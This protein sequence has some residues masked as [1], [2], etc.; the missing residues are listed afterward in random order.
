MIL[1]LLFSQLMKRAYRSLSYLENMLILNFFLDFLRQRI[2]PAHFLGSKELRL[3]VMLRC[4]S[5]HPSLKVDLPLIDSQPRWFAAFLK[6]FLRLLFKRIEL[7]LEL[8]FLQFGEG[9][10][11]RVLLLHH[12][13]LAHLL[14]HIRSTLQ[15]LTEDVRVMRCK[16]LAL[17]KLLHLIMDAGEEIDELALIA[18]LSY[19]KSIESFC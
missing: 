1:D 11:E 9:L 4:D 17:L 19:V 3:G 2:Q 5:L 18:V 7:Y 6:L 10:I 15:E 14:H 16:V 12:A 8:T 13:Q